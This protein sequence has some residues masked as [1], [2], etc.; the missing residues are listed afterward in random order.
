MNA[1]IR[2]LREDEGDYLL[3]AFA[4]GKA[5]S[6]AVLSHTWSRNQEDEVTFHD[7]VLGEGRRKVGYEKLRF[8]GRQ[9]KQDGLDFFWIDTCCIDKTDIEELQTSVSLM[10]QTY[11]R[12]EKCYALLSD[13][14]MGFVEEGE[15]L[16]SRDWESS[17]AQS[18]WFTRGW[19]LQ[20]LLAP[21]SVEFYSQEGIYIGSKH[22]LT[23]QLNTISGISIQ[24]LQGQELDTFDIDERLSWAKSR[25]TTM[26][27]D[28]AYCLFGIFG[29]SMKIDYGEGRQKAWARLLDVI[30]GQRADPIDRL[31]QS[32]NMTT[33]KIL[34]REEDKWLHWLSSSD[35]S[36]QQD[37]ILSRRQE[38]TGQWFIN[39][40][41]FISWVYGY[42]HTLLCLGIPGA[43]KTMIAAI[44]IDR[45]KAIVEGDNI[46][47]AWVYYNYRFQASQ[48]PSAL[49]SA[50][51]KQLVRNRP[52]FTPIVKALHDS[53]DEPGSR[54]E[55]LHRA[56]SKV[57]ASLDRTYIVVDALDECSDQ[58]GAR[59]KLIEQLQALQQV[60]KVH[61]FYTSR[62]VPEVVSSIPADAVMRIHTQDDDARLYIV[63]QYHRMPEFVQK[64]RELRETITDNIVSVID[65]M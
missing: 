18:R 50:L 22:T 40:P 10:Y 13:V 43:G 6:Y 41:D 47:V 61:L 56:L 42:S 52:R 15:A 46:G 58:Y 29:I 32:D 2:L 19:T 28:M 12:A 53:R 24:A 35:F 65:G 54:L 26:E 7:I 48:G 59:T 17:F 1:I 27:E 23:K 63:G 20:E 25:E 33:A 44:A 37:V 11:E 57:L 64:S 60:A 51:L 34:L 30:Q 14:S 9:A 36:A 5:P 21:H 39:A 49:L 16:A 62:P 3:Q 8:C 38:G 4:R 55:E 31:G 45:L